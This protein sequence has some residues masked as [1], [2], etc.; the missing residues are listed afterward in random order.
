MLCA[1]VFVMVRKKIDSKLVFP[2][3]HAL[4]EKLLRATCMVDR[5]MSERREQTLV[6][7]NFN[8]PENKH[9]KGA[10]VSYHRA[11]FVEETLKNLP[12]PTVSDFVNN[13]KAYACMT[14]KTVG[15]FCS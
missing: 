10:F 15:I 14:R 1:N 8:K 6:V 11:G 5:L 3:R 13:S 4:A 12:N 9:M 7:K 2:P